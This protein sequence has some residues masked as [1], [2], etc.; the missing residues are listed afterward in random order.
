M[1]GARSVYGAESTSAVEKVN[2]AR[3]RS[4]ANER[5]V[6]VP[7]YRVHVYTQHAHSRVA[8]VEV[9]AKDGEKARDKARAELYRQGRQPNFLTL[10]PVEVGAPANPFRT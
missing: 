10:V 3:I 9:R 1:S 4:V 5:G 6:V 8:T 2:P 7:A